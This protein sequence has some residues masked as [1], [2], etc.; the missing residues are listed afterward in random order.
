MKAID[1]LRKMAAAALTVAALGTIT[2]FASPD[3]AASSEKEVPFEVRLETE[4]TERLCYAGHKANGVQYRDGLAVT[5]DA[6][7]SVVDKGIDGTADPSRLSVKLILLYENADN[8]GSLKETVRTYSEGDLSADGTLYPFFSES[9]VESLSERDKL[10]SNSLRGIE[11]KI[12]YEAQKSKKTETR[13]YMVCSE[14]D[15]YNYSEAGEQL[16]AEE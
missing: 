1:F 2:V 13:Y 11:M 4:S 9:N 10:Y 3:G 6:A 12:S 14:D 15:L 16:T 7:F 8:T 5:P